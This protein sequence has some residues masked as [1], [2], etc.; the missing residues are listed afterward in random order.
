MR[1][2]AE[3]LDEQGRR[4]VPRARPRPFQARQR[5][6]RPPRRRQ[7]AAPRRARRCTKAAPKGACCARTGGDEFAILLPGASAQRPRKSSAPRSSPDLADPDVRRGRADP[8]YRVDRPCPSVRARRRRRLRCAR[9]T[10]RSMPPSA[11]GRN[12]FAWFD[13]EL[14]REIDRPAEA[15]RG[16]PRAASRRASSSRSS[17]RCRLSTAAQIIGFEALARWRSPSRGFLEAETFIETAERTGLIGPLTMSVLEQ[18][19]KEARAWPAHLQA[20]GQR[21][22]GPVPRPARSPSRS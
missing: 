18:A 13:E 20:R 12:S 6:S 17:S 10:S 16:Y 1:A 7:G 9:A 5:P 2:L 3:A 11:R 21:F 14:E 4:R 15:R 19:L 22:A 8:G